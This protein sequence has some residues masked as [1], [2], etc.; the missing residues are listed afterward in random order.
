MYNVE[1][2]IERCLRSCLNQNI[3]STDYEIILVNDGSE[4]STLKIAESVL[5]GCKNVTIISQKNQGLSMA[6]N[7]GL[8]IAK[9]DY[10]WFVDSDDWLEANMLR[11][12]INVCYGS[13]IVALGYI[14]AHDRKEEDVFV[15]VRL[16]HETSGIDFLRS[17][18]F[19][20][21]AQLYIYRRDFLEKNELRFYP[22][23]FHEDMEFTARM[24][25][26]AGKVVVFNTP[27][28]YFYVRP[29][30]ITTTINPKKSYDLITVARNLSSFSKSINDSSCKLSFNRVIAL[31]LNNALFS[32]DKF[33]ESD[34][35]KLSE[36]LY[37]NRDLFVHLKKTG[38]MKYMIEG[39]LF[40]LFPRNV[41]VIYRVMQF[42]NTKTNRETI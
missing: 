35:D 20:T 7:A 19:F 5:S 25:Y 8:S 40:E 26:K 27:L 21:P 31:A 13:D 32:I 41:S 4:D 29:N 34:I 16:M 39:F 3:P 9:G 17:Y 37:E 33:G 12:V 6:R 36:L 22:G 24:L 15:P 11:D 42:F 23:I 14:K 10:V 28:Y 2:Y 18:N 38:I 1:L 30:S